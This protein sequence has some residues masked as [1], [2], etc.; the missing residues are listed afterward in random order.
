MYMKIIFTIFVAAVS[1]S[2]CN[3]LDF[4]ESEGKT[5]EEVYSYFDNI[6]RMTSAVYRRVPVDYGVIGGAL[7]EAA[8][9]NAVY[10]WDN[11]AV[12]QIYSDA[13]SPIRLVDNQWSS[14]YEVIHDANSFLENYTEEYLERF[15]WDPN[16]PDN[17]AKTRMYINEIKV[18]RALYHFELA[19]R[20]GDIPL[21]TRTY[22]LDEINYIE[23]TSFD[24]IIEF[25]VDQIDAVASNLPEDQKEFYGETG[26]VTKGAALAIKARA[27][28]YA[29]SPLF[30]GTGDSSAKWQAAA[31]A[32]YDVIALNRY[33][34]PN[35]N[36][37][38]LYQTEG[39]NVVL[40]SPQ[41]IFEFRGSAKSDFEARN[42]P[43]GFEG[44]NGGNTPTQNLVD[45]YEMA[46]GV[47]FDWTN[48]KHVANIYYDSEGKPT[49][50][51][52]LYLNVIC[53]GMTYMKTKVEPLEGGKHGL[54]ITGATMTG[55]YLK[56]LMNETVS[57]DPVKPVQKEHHFPTYRYAEILL[58]YAEAMNEWKGPDAID[59]NNGCPISARDALNQVRTAANMKAI[60]DTDPGEFSKKV[61]K[62]RRIELAF[63]DHRF[64]DIRRWKMGSVVENIYGINK[65]NGIYQKRV[66][67][68]RVWRDKMYLY[69]IP[70]NEIY[71]NMNL[72]QNPGW[73]SG[74]N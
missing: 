57:L 52:R 68:N 37:D 63:E 67:Q 14:F 2:G 11:N 49:R 36:D 61:R 66:I 1:L 38:K 27:L 73:N 8:T 59:A 72:T 18:L 42:L 35:I 21:V 56:K 50:D 34:L 69:P 28:L 22:S 45:D 55:Y 74:S 29:A 46:D 25:V 5:K 23:K 26:R 65:V 30:A 7:R 17:M 54:P 9:D 53:D 16:Y 13:W 39:G 31:K 41:L 32:A 58:N 64:W 24:K 20:Y 70:Q 47:P 60:A 71:A 6:T 3:Y 51:P 62:E 4:D 40:D 15:K 12:Y 44:A 33:S 48:P 19:K 43:I 10:T